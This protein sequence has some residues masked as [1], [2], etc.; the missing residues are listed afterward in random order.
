MPRLD[1]TTLAAAELGSE[2]RVWLRRR[3]ERPEIL[4]AALAYELVAVVGKESASEAQAVAL[5]DRWAAHMKRQ[6]HAFGVGV[7]HP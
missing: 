7:E 4:A 5:I 1:P 3:A 2:L 6:I